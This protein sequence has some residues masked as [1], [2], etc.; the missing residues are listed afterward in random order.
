MGWW[1]CLGGAAG[2]AA[3]ALGGAG[4]EPAGAG[5]A[6]DATL[7]HGMTISCQTNGREWASDGFG[8]EVERLAAL[9]VNWVAIHPYG[10]IRRDGTLEWRPID[11]E[12][13]PEMVARPIREARSRGVAILVTPHLAQWGSG[14]RSRGDIAFAD[15]QERRRFFELYRE[16]I[17]QLAAAAREADAFAVGNE[18]DGLV[19][20][21]AE[22]R[23]VIAAVREVTPARLTYAANWTHF[24]RVGFWDALDAI[25]VQGYFPLSDLEQPGE[26]DLRAGWQAA[27]ARMRAVHERTGKPVV[28]TELGYNCSLAAAR[29]PWDHK[30]AAPVDR[31]RA[32]EL[33]AACLRIALEEI[34]R[35][36]RW[37]R[38][39]FLWKWFVGPAPGENFRLDTP[40]LRAV[41]AG[42]WAAR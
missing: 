8:P 33:Q 12:R 23:E 7:V 27:L 26:E 14:F 28:L 17:V 36:E 3:V 2:L 18:L 11:P 4:A 42:A 38:G 16:W 20:C 32:E 34:A 29:E 39:A 25:G 40:E 1:S 30:S 41:I 37:L 21:E 9:G 15:P 19:D 31:Q 35:E 10:R 5:S 22:W 6:G 13:P 24:E